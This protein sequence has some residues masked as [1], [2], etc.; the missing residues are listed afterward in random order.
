MSCKEAR[1]L[2]KARSLGWSVGESVR[3]VIDH[4]RVG[5]MITYIYSKIR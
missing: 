3:S 2:L 1:I 5:K 4:P